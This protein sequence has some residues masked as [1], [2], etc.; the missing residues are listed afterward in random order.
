M[1]HDNLSDLPDRVRNNLPE[2][3][4]E[5]YRAAFNSAEEQYAPS[6]IVGSRG[7]SRRLEPLRTSLGIS[8]AW[9]TDA[10]LQASPI[11]RSGAIGFVDTLLSVCVRLSWRSATWKTPSR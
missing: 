7:S 4:Q 9:I 6:R 5:I 11:R 8:R 2:H 1:P 10:T 3:A